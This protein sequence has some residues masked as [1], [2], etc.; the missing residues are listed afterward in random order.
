MTAPRPPAL[1]A[2]ARP[3]RAG[4]AASLRRLLAAVRAALRAAGGNRAEAAR[5]LGVS[6]RAL[7]GWLADERLAAEVGREIPATLGW[8]REQRE[9]RA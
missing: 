2:L 3:A 5:A 4:D 8:R 6:P 9:G 7:L 1:A